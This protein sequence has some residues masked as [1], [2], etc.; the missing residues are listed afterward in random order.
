MSAE[1]ILS[2]C[3]KAKRTGPANWIACCPAHDDKSPSMTVRE[4]EDGRVLLHC[5][6][7]CSVE[8][9]IGALGVPWDALFPEK[10]ISGD[11][12]PPHRKPF[13]AADILAAVA[14]DAMR[15]AVFAANVGRKDCEITLDDYVGMLNAAGRILEA[16]RLALG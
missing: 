9:I 3:K 6:G 16:R 15:V 14:D 5:F 8:S 1:A 11:F 7:G 10:P 4:L 2:G 13:P 12:K